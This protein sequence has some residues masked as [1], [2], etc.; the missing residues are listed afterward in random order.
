[1]NQIDIIR[2][3]TYELLFKAFTSD[4][5]FNLIK[6]PCGC[7]KTK[8]SVDMIRNFYD[9]PILHLSP[10]KDNVLEI[11]DKYCYVFFQ[12][13]FATYMIGK[14]SVCGNV[15]LKELF[16][17]GITTTKHICEKCEWVE[18]CSY[19]GLLDL[20]YKSNT[21]FTSVYYLLEEMI[22]QFIKKKNVEIIYIDED[23]VKIM[24]VNF[25]ISYP[26]LLKNHEFCMSISNSDYYEKNI[27]PL[28]KGYIDIIMDTKDKDSIYEKIID[29]Y[30]NIDDDILNDYLEQYQVEYIDK[31]LESPELVPN[32]VFLPNMLRVLY[33]FYNWCE[34]NKISKELT[35]L[36]KFINTYNYKD[37]RY[38][39]HIFYDNSP[40]LQL[41]SMGIKIINGNATADI[42]QFKMIFNIKDEDI[43][44]QECDFE[45][46]VNI[47]EITSG[48][49]PISTILQHPEVKD[50][51]FRL[52]K[53][54]CS[55]FKD[56]KKI[57]VISKLT[58]EKEVRKLNDKII[59]QHY[60]NLEGKNTF[61]LYDRMILLGTPYL[62]LEEYDR[63]SVYFRVGREDLIKYDKKKHLNQAFGRLRSIISSNKEILKITKTDIG[64]KNIGNTY[65]FSTEEAIKVF[66]YTYINLL[67]S[68]LTTKRDLCKLLNCY[69][70]EDIFKYL[71][72]NNFLKIIDGKYIKC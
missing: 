35:Q 70:N 20:M 39:E 42:E 67:P 23:P 5:Q 30:D 10:Y 72:N 6:S 3:K 37:E 26:D 61:E 44:Y 62:E 40:F 14:S 51:L 47:I 45:Q 34:A 63:M 64:I 66:D 28:V 22:F 33:P 31:Y 15:N 7:G 12:E 36:H 68:E 8:S 19:F 27:Y 59:T 65:R 16:K 50:K 1:M 21:L 57:P 11:I 56:D 25:K 53:S 38:I 17:R 49:Y 24:H 18:K 58:I 29:F 69:K 41:K 4:K 2:E 54:Y 32:Q 60:F 48:E 13:P 46:D 55:F 71:I 9:K 52:I 43:F